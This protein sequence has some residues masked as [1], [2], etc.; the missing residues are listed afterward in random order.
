MVTSRGLRVLPRWWR[1]SFLEEAE[2]MDF[3]MVC[4]STESPPALGPPCSSP[5][6]PDMPP[7]CSSGCRPAHPLRAFA[8]PPP[9]ALEA[10][11]SSLHLSYF[12]GRPAL[13]DRCPLAP[14]PW[15]SSPESC[16]PVLVTQGSRQQ[17]AYLF[18]SPFATGKQ[19]L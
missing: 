10:L 12:P 4:S 5:A 9:S 16:F 18:P 3:R 15:T 11:V 2:R 6:P 7:L 8:P 17:K 19:D 13:P 1:I 14:L